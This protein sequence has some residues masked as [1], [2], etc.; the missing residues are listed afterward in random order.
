M[1]YHAYNK[2][3]SATVIQ[4][5]RVNR[6]TLIHQSVVFAQVRCGSK[7]LWA[8]E[9]DRKHCSY[10]VDGF[11]HLVIL[12]T[13]DVGGVLVLTSLSQKLFRNK[14]NAAVVLLVSLSRDV[15]LIRVTRRSA[16]PNGPFT[17]TPFKRLYVFSPQNPATRHS[18]LT[19]LVL[20]ARCSAT[21]REASLHGTL[22][23]TTRAGTLSGTIILTTRYEK[24][25]GLKVMI[26]FC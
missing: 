20:L 13:V 17:T 4:F 24:S 25:Y 23:G 18:C 7:P 16:K 26:M 15:S 2:L 11:I 5:P 12:D 22:R 14:L 19:S 6:K 9:E 3:Y 21:A 10:H 8:P 1:L